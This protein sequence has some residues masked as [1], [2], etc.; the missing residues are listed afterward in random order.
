MNLKSMKIGDRVAGMFSFEYYAHL[1]NPRSG[2]IDVVIRLLERP[3]IIRKHEES[4][5]LLDQFRRTGR[6][7]GD[8]STLL[9]LEL[10]Y[11][12]RTKY[13]FKEVT[14]DA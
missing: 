13:V 12:N 14:E 10:A 5:Y 11:V 7:V 2:V 4:V 6:R 8:S 1:I 9:L 3:C